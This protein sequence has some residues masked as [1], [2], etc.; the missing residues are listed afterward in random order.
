LS[1]DLFNPTV[2]SRALGMVRKYVL[3]NSGEMYDVDDVMHD[4]LIIYFQ[5]VSQDDFQ[6]TVKPE[7]YILK[8]CKNLWLK[9]LS[10]KKRVI[11]VERHRDNIEDNQDYLK[12][13]RERKEVLIALIDRNVKNL[14]AKCRKLFEYK[15]EGLSCDEISELMNF[16]NRQISKDKTYRCKKR[17]LFLI[18]Q[19]PEYRRMIEDE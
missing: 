6:L 11:L 19:D 13:I 18:Q 1:P 17:L 8:V 9:E 4:G 16:N 12:K 7:Y 3:Q 14:S 5:K 2:Y 10:K 15:M